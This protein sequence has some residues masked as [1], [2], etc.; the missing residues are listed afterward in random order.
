M[1][2][3]RQKKIPQYSSPS[4][5]MHKISVYETPQNSVAK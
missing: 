4:H 1:R 2:K 3:A 5:S